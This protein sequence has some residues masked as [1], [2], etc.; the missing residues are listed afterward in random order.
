M[1]AAPAA[2]IRVSMNIDTHGRPR[3]RGPRVGRHRTSW[4]AGN[5]R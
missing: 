3:R 5:G 1:D 2:L 4:L